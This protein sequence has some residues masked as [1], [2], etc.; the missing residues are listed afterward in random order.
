MRAARYHQSSHTLSL[1]E[2]ADPE[3]QPHEVVVKVAACGVCLSD[4]HLIDGSLPGPLAEVIPGHEAAGVVES[5]GEAVP[6]W[7]PGARVVI[8]G[9]RPCLRCRR[10][11]SGRQ[12]QCQ[13]FEI[14]GFHYDGA[15]AE[16]VAVPYFALTAVP[17]AV[18]IEQ[19]AILADAVSTPFAALIDRAGLR[20]GEA[21]G[22]WGA[23]GLGVHAIQLARLMGAA[24]IVAVDP[25]PAARDR[26][27]RCGADAALDPAK[28]VE[29]AIRALT[30]GAGLDVALDVV[31][32]NA[33][34]AQAE[35]CLGR[36]GRLVMVGMFL[37]PIQLGPAVLMSVQ[38]QS[39][40]GHLGYRKEH[41]EAL[42]RLLALN[43]LD[44]SGS[45]SASFALD[46]VAEAVGQ[47]AS[48]KGNPVRL[49]IRP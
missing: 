35:R 2:V 34:L 1:V 4:V 46:D 20:P 25:L 43:R 29:P 14:M 19:A 33:V 7:R 42:V 27:L 8:A 16:R 28:E 11:A 41:L 22:V 31:G 3:P 37:E 26:A 18:P 9:G 36:G 24:P 39:L 49:V 5:V 21:V 12:E 48:K 10:C 38:S 30:D 6:A 13:A 23:G 40:L 45:I 15:W 47:L 17:D 32:A 44:L